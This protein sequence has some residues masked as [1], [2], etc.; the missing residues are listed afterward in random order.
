MNNHASELVSK[1]RSFIHSKKVDLLSHAEINRLFSSFSFG[2]PNK[3]S[4]GELASINFEI[5]VEEAIQSLGL[6]KEDDFSGKTVLEVGGGVGLCHIWLQMNRLDIVSIEPSLVGHDSYFRAGVEL[7]KFFGLDATRWMPL[8]ADQVTSIGRKFDLIF[9][10]NVIEHI[11]NLDE[12]FAQMVAVMK[13]GGEMRHACPNYALPYEPHF[14]IFMIPFAEKFS[15]FLIKK[16]WDIDLWRGLNFVTARKVRRLA[17]AHGLEVQFEQGLLYKAL[18]RMDFDNN[19]QQKR[20]GIF[21]IYRL[22]KALKVLAIFNWAPAEWLT[23]MSF[24]VR[25]K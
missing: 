20:P 11:S 14:N 19:F 21:A 13:K 1:F 24:R 9:S 25:G 16:D 3:A 18:T 7:V 15:S 22:L 8:R 23:P 12:S 2:R 5:L 4:G 6:L 10:N 17:R